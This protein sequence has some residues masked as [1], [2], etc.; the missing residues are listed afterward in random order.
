MKLIYDPIHGYMS[1]PKKVVNV[2]DTPIVKRLKYLKQLGSCYEVFPGASH[3]RFEHSI[4]VAYLA[5]KFIDKLELNCKSFIWSKEQIM[6]AGLCHD[7]GHGPGSHIWDNEILPIRNINSPFINHE[8]RSKYM[9]EQ[10][11]CNQKVSLTHEDIVFIQELI[12]PTKEYTDIPYHI[13]H[14]PKHGIDVDKFDYLQRDCYNIGLEYSWDYIRLMNEAK[15]INNQI[16]YPKKLECHIY[17]MYDTRYRLHK[18]IF[19]HPVV[20]SIEYMMR[21]AILL[22]DEHL[23]IISRTLDDRFQTLTDHIFTEILFSTDKELKPARLLLQRIQNRD[24]YKFVKELEIPRNTKIDLIDIIPTGE[25]VENYILFRMKHPLYS[26]YNDYINH[27]PLYYKGKIEK[28]TP[29]LPI[30]IDKLYDT[31]KLFKL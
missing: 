30:D 2:M 8:Y 4:G 26:F 18:E 5:G 22:A 28:A 17:R 25:D 31:I 20:K 23:D 3:N 15:I 6:I 1:F 16:Y 12:E 21:D 11:V 24:L 27:I 29:P 9:L 13:I 14:H 7:L 10:L 19:N